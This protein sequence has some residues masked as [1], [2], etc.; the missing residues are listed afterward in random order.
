MVLA[1]HS[2]VQSLTVYMVSSARVWM[3]RTTEFDKQSKMPFMN[4]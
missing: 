4:S 2:A 3:V 1:V